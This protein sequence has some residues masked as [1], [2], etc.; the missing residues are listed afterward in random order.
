MREGKTLS[1]INCESAVLGGASAVCPPRS[2]RL[3]CLFFSVDQVKF[4][5]LLEKETQP[6]H[7]PVSERGARRQR[8]SALFLAE[9]PHCTHARFGVQTRIWGGFALCPN[10]PNTWLLLA[11]I[12]CL[13]KTLYPSF[14]VRPTRTGF[15]VNISVHTSRQ[16]QT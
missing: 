4:N 1:E 2:S 9:C 8:V 11:R 14:D 3:F 15:V 10:F 7:K 12:N 5:P 16:V 6:H 13:T